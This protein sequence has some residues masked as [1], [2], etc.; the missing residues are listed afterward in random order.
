[1]AT[2]EADIKNRPDQWRYFE[3]RPFTR[4]QRDYTTLVFGGLTRAH[5]EIVRGA[6]K[7]LGYTAEIIPTPTA[8]DFQ[9]GKE[10]G[11]YGQCSPTYFTS[12]ALVNYLKTIE[13]REGLTKEQVVDRYA[14]ITP[15]SPCGPCRLGMYQNEY[16]LATSNAGFVGFRILG[17]NQR[18]EPGRAD[19]DSGLNITTDFYLSL[20][21]SILVGDLLN[22]VGHAIRPYEVNPGDTDA[23][24]ARCRSHME[25]VVAGMTFPDLEDMAPTMDRIAKMWPGKR[26]AIDTLVRVRRWFGGANLEVLLEG[27]RQC[28]EWYNDIEIDRTTIKPIVKITG[29][30]WAQTT[31]GD[32]NYDMFR[33]LDSEG[34]QIMVEPVA[35]WFYYLLHGNRQDVED[36][37]HLIEKDNIDVTFWDRI[38]AAANQKKKG[39]II[40]LIDKAYYNLYKKMRE[41]FDGIPHDLVDMHVLEELGHPF[42]HS[43]AEGGEGHLEVGKNIYYHKNHL[44]HMVLSVKPFGCMPSTQSDATQAAALGTYG[45]MIYLPI[46]TSGEGKVNAHSRV[47]MALGE[48]KMKTKEEFE[49]AQAETG[50]TRD[51]V[52]AYLEEHPELKRPAYHLPQHPE[53]V[54]VAA[55]LFYHV[56]D[57]MDGKVELGAA[58]AAHA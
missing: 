2:T 47:Q 32:G 58:H 33:F 9:T 14:Y 43:R 22:E 57:L 46:E 55:N 51:E 50:L 52:L 49:R 53:T 19:A 28:Q 34:A 18:P 29:E 27:M 41:A 4:E 48:A 20:V 1:M 10:Y 37:A 39:A 15:E 24:V 3:Q 7:A 17:L 13:V 35:T 21:F 8:G 31:D 40:E 25:N 12:G 42:Y 5:E 6:L 44:A 23:V 36:E 38:K 16:R 56:K 30:F 11:N 54:G 45:D 26:G